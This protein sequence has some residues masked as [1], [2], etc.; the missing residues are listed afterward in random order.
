[1][2]ARPQLRAMALV[3][4]VDHQAEVEQSEGWSR[5]SE[6]LRDEVGLLLLA[7]GQVLA[8]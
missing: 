2:Y 5:L 4:A 7:A 8:V 1:M 6:A 3:F